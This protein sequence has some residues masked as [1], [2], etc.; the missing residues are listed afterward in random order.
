MR[1][2][3]NVAVLLVMLITLAISAPALAAFVEFAEV[4]IDVDNGTATVSSTV[5]GE[6]YG[7]QLDVMMAVYDV[8]GNLV[9]TKPY[10]ITITDSVYG[11]VY[12]SKALTPWV[13]DL[14]PGSYSIQYT[15]SESVYEGPGFT[16]PAPSGSNGDGGSGG[17]GGG[18]SGPV[19]QGDGS[20]LLSKNPVLD[21]KTKTAAATVSSKDFEAALE[22]AVADANGIKTI[23]IDV[24]KVAGAESYLVNLPQSAVAAGHAG[25][26]VVLKTDKGTVTLPSNMFEPIDGAEYGISIGQADKTGIPEDVAAKIGDRPVIE[27]KAYINGVETKWSNPDA[28]VKV[29][30]PYTP[31]TS[32]L[33]NAEYITVWYIDDEG[34]V[35]PVPSGRYDAKEKA[36]VFTTTH[37]SKFAVTYV[38]KSFNDVSEFAWAQKQ[39]SVLASKGIING[40][41]ATTFAPKAN[42]TR[43]DFLHLLV[44]TLSLSAKTDSNF[45]D[46]KADA[47]YAESVAIAKK[48][49]ITNGVGN[50]KFD[51]SASISRQD[52]MVL[53]YKALELV[54]KAP[55]GTVEDIASFKDS[56]DVASY[57]VDSVAALI[58][59]EIV[60]GSN[61]SI[62]PKGL[63]TRAEAAVIL[64]RVYNK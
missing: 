47:Y 43:A 37:F 23:V 53:T 18:S 29:S 34:N 14:A 20:V 25:I 16:V 17:S 55:V 46:I 12:Y 1:L 52:M 57:A 26:R 3:K 4:V 64:Y 22:K 5:Y 32:E 33:Q 39:I 48:L 54:K 50:N 21:S 38:V 7:E 58:N 28:P 45:S 51:P 42:I 49:G 8:N 15:V 56:S 35:T 41:S 31:T 9:V 6:V 11:S 44:K 40:T 2:K 62:N 63:S 30:V 61:N 13:I 36:V 24:A 59:G 10:S 19:V 60:L 27:L